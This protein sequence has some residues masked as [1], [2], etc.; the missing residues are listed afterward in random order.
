MRVGGGRLIPVDVRIITASNR[1]LSDMVEKDLF[2]KDLFY[3]INVLFLKI[4]SLRERQEDI[5]V[6]ARHFIRKYA[7]IYQ[8]EPLNLDEETRRLLQNVHYD[9]NVRELENIIERAVILSSFDSLGPL[10]TK[11]SGQSEWKEPNTENLTWQ[12]GY[13]S[14]K[15]LETWYIEK[16]FKEHHQNVQRTCEVL[17]ISRSTL[18]RKL[19]KQPHDV[20]D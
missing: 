6:L 16:V 11:A 13:Q 12:G 9:G 7:A 19:S 1:K 17:G 8:K 15:E 10:E 2:R 14:L 18:W 3:R 20:S 4:P 5:P